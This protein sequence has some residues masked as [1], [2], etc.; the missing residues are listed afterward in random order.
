MAVLEIIKR[1]F[2]NEV[3]YS[4]R[5]G[6]LLYK[7]GSRDDWQEIY[8][9][10]EKIANENIGIKVCV[11]DL[12]IDPGLGARFK[13]TEADTPTLLILKNGKE[14]GRS[15]KLIREEEIFEILKT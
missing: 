1:N 6:L 8:S 5:P 4:D 12:E 9:V 15:Q 7:S 2:E 10:I 11:V 13:V 3:V 14:R